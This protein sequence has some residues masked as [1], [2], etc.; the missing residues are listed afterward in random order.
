MLPIRRRLVFQAIILLA[1]V[2]CG[3]LVNQNVTPCGNNPNAHRIY[4]GIRQEL[5]GAGSA[6]DKNWWV[7]LD[8]PFT[9]IG[10]T[11]C[12][13]LDLVHTC[14]R[15]GDEAKSPNERNPHEVASG[16]NVEGSDR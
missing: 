6:G 2:G 9:L 1:A 16:S 11:V 7:L 12:L 10:D 5:A 3:T 8:V 13:P 15:Q 14:L 4:G